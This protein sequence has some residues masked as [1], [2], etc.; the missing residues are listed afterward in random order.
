MKFY[1]LKKFTFSLSDAQNYLTI[2][3]H[4]LKLLSAI[5]TKQVLYKKR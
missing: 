3:K 4:I 2:M 5:V 1:N